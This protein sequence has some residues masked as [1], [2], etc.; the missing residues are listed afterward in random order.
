MH[1]VSIKD[2]YTCTKT[3]PI[4]LNLSG[5]NGVNSCYVTFTGGKGHIILTIC[6]QGGGRVSEVKSEVTSLMDNPCD[7]TLWYQKQLFSG[8]TVLN[9][10]C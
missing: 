4:F 7:C 9:F 1:P 3:F 5:V 6:D 10:Y 2:M 8:R